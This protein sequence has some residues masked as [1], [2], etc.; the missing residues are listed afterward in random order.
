[1]ILP[2][3]QSNS[4][5]QALAVKHNCKFLKAG[6]GFL[7]V[8]EFHKV[9]DAHADYDGEWHSAYINTGDA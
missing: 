4:I 3:I 8:A 9:L 2:N 1:M 5:I 7:S 6:T